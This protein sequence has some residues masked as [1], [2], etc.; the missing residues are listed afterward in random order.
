VSVA[1]DTEVLITAFAIFL[2]FILV[3]LVFVLYR[4]SHR[5]HVY[6]DIDLAS[7]RTVRKLRKPDGV[8]VNTKWGTYRL[9]PDVALTFKGRPLFRYQQGDMRPYSPRIAKLTDEKG[10]TYEVRKFEPEYVPA[11]SFQ[12]AMK[13]NIWAQIYRPTVTTLL[14]V[15]VVILILAVMGLYLKG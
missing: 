13:S 10:T 2:P 6:V 7:S 14:L 9:V 15:L 4:W 12:T 11:E 8:F 3:P 1:S 5:N